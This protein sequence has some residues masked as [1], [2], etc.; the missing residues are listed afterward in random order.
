M[1]T[2]LMGYID[3]NLLPDEIIAF[4]TKKQ[5]FIIFMPAI[6]FLLIAIFFSISN[7]ITDS[8]NHAFRDTTFGNG[9]NHFAAI[10]FLLVAFFTGLKQ[11]LLYVTS[12]YAVT[13]KRVIM[14]EGFFKR[15][16]CDTR[17][18]SISIEQPLVGQVFNYGTIIIKGFGGSTDYFVQV[19]HPNLFQKCVHEQLD[20]I[21]R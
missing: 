6:T 21:G 2:L 7:P 16:I 12:D 11:W 14:K 8:I 20:K 13:N 17:L 4:R 1:D 15:Y 10:V 18:A 5:G 19:A 3:K 9:L